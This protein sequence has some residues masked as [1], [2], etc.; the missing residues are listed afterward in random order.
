MPEFR[1]AA[2]AVSR[3]PDSVGDRVTVGG[4]TTTLES[5]RGTTR[6]GTRRAWRPVLRLV[7]VAT[8]APRMAVRT[9]WTSAGES[10]PGNPATAA[11]ERLNLATTRALECAATVTR[12]ALM[13]IRA[14]NR[15][16]TNV[17]VSA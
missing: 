7:G 11:L 1:T 12:A 14:P 17:D 10:M 6:N 16:P 4:V 13:L 9:A 8:T 15:D 5:P 2:V 3:S